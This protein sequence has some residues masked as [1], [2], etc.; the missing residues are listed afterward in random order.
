MRRTSFTG[1]SS[2]FNEKQV[3]F[4]GG[5]PIV[6]D[7]A[8]FFGSYEYQDRAITVAPEHA[9]S[10]SSTSTSRR[11]SKRHYVTARADVQ[12][13]HAAPA[14]RARLDLQLGSDQRGRRTAARRVSAATRV[15]PTNI[16]VSIGDTWVISSRARE[17]SPRRL[18]AHRQP[19]QL[20][21]ADAAPELPVGDPRLADQLAAV[22]EGDEHRSST[23]RS[24]Y[25][26]P[27]LARRAQHEGAGSSSSGRSSG[28]RSRSQPF[29]AFNFSR[30][31]ADFN[32]PATY[33]APTSYSIPLGDTSYKREQSDLRGVLPGQLDDQPQADAESRRALRRRDRHDEHRFARPGRARRAA[34]R[35]RQLRAARR[36]RLR[37]DAATAA[38]SC[39]AATAATTTR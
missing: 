5:G 4:N 34:H 17:R 2:P 11:T 32:D 36:L 29:G 25:F 8:H 18:L 3:G 23:T 20:E 22:V 31:P 33:P 14:V 1:A 27:E 13:E 6:R 19:A 10:R 26:V 21:F 28:A 37:P 35:R 16:D 9:A 15:R 30:D 12:L 24:A 38:R 7:R 39:A